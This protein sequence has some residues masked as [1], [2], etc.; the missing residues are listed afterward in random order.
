[1]ATRKRGGNKLPAI[2]AAA[3]RVF[4]EKGYHSATIAEIARQAKV[5][6]ATVYE[7][8]GSKEDLL[9]MIP[10]EITRAAVE[11]MEKTLPFIKGPENRL[12]AIIYGYYSVYRDNP[13][14]SALVLLDL[15]HNREFMKTEGYHEVRRAAGLLLQILEDGIA[16]GDFRDDMDPRLIRSMVLGT[17]EHVFFRWHL[18]GRKE[19]LPDF[20]DD[21]TEMVIRGIRKGEE[22]K[23]VRLRID[24]E[25]GDVRVVEEPKA[26]RKKQVRKPVAGG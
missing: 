19:E 12:R 16:R 18:L 3:L 26:A 22:E 6:E 17:I 10:D 2:I 24:V 7:Y 25:E 8:C 14:Y 21:L 11:Q 13:E 4:S 5:S 1:V 15:K 20:V 23:V 9:F